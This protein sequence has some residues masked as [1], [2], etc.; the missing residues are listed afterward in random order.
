MTVEGQDKYVCMYVYM[1]VGMRV[2]LQCMY[3]CVCVPLT[4]TEFICTK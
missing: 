4:C 2:M 3:V 1:Y